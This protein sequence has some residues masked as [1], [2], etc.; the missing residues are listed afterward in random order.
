MS[1]KEEFNLRSYVKGKSG[2]AVRDVLPL[3]HFANTPVLRFFM[4]IFLFIHMEEYVPKT[5]DEDFFASVG[6]RKEGETNVQKLI[7]HTNLTRTLKLPIRQQMYLLA[8]EAGHVILGHLLR[9]DMFDNPKL[10]N[11]A[12]DSVLNEILNASYSSVMEMPKSPEG[13]TLGVTVSSLKKQGLLKTGKPWNEL[14]AEEIYLLMQEQGKS[15]SPQ[16]IE[17]MMKQMAEEMMKQLGGQPQSGQQGEK[18]TP[19]RGK[20]FEELLD[21]LDKQRLD[22]HDH[23][24]DAKNLSDEV[25]HQIENMIKQAKSDVYGT[26]AGNFV[27]NLMSIVPKDFPFSQVLEPIIYREKYNFSRPSRRVKMKQFPS[28]IPNKRQEKIKVYV[29]IDVSGSTDGYIEDFLGYVMALPEFEEV[30]YCDTQIQHII[31]KGDPIPPMVPGLGGT[32]LN[33]V[34]ERFAEHER[35]KKGSEKLNFLILTDGELGAVE[36]GPKDSNVIVF[37]THCLVKYSE[38]R[39]PWINIEI[40]P[41]HI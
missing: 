35:N 4:E 20:T 36:T 13:K 14:S 5:A 27:R 3:E 37:T 32:N 41:D 19:G 24:L 11:I 12:I 40:E 10:W 18:D 33:P 34:F 8:H 17:E 25:R 21:E 38:A 9:C 22:E 2:D 26:E 16:E 7:M 15:M 28:F 29:G 39:R 6:S 30:V 31:R 23:S 1:E